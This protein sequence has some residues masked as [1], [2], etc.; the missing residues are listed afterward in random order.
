MLLLRQTTI[1]KSPFSDDVDALPKEDGDLLGEGAY[2]KVYRTSWNGR[3]LATKQATCVNGMEHEWEIL[4]SLRNRSVVE[5]YASPSMDTL[6]MDTLYMEYLPLTVDGFIDDQ[7][8]KK[9][10]N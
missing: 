7:I 9:N 4:S 6:C 8:Q 10:F 3:T 5:V 2:S 1:A